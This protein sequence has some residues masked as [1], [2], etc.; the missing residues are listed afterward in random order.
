[1]SRPTYNILTPAEAAEV[2]KLSRAADAAADDGHDQRLVDAWQAA[3]ELALGAVGRARTPEGLQ[4]LAHD[5]GRAADCRLDDAAADYLDACLD[6]CQYARGLAFLPSLAQLDALPPEELVASRAE[7]LGSMGQTEEAERVLLEELA[8]RPDDALTYVTLGDLYY[9]M[10]MDSQRDYR[11]ALEWYYAGYDRGL[12]REE[13]EDGS[14]L[15]ERL[16]DC[17]ADHL[18]NLARERLLAAL[19][20]RGAGDWQDLAVAEHAIEH[21]VKGMSAPPAATRLL[22]ALTRDVPNDAAFQPLLDL[23]LDFLNLCPRELLKGHSDYVGRAVARQLENLPPRD[24]DEPD[25]DE[26]QDLL[27]EGFKPFRHQDPAPGFTRID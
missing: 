4:A 24:P 25:L 11:R 6:S 19:R 27:W 10:P 26:P 13:D 12:A 8:E 14:L 20:E 16:A 5:F 23:Y 9:I 17:T 7:F 3:L 18:L 1:M 2:A 22:E 15:L 21:Q